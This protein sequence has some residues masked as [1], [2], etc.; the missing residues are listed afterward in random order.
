MA[1]ALALSYHDGGSDEAEVCFLVDFGSEAAKCFAKLGTR[2]TP[3][4]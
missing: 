3:R 4:R 1:L 2:E